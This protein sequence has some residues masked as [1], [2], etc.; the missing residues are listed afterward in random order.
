MAQHKADDMSRPGLPDSESSFE[1]AIVGFLCNWCSYAG[2][3]LAGTSRLS[4]PTNLRVIR[5]MCSGRVDPGLMLEPFQ[6]GAD[7]VM[8]LGCHPA[9][10]HY[11]S[12]NYQAEQ[13]VL[14]V[15]A[16][17]DHLGIDKG[18]LYLD[19]VSAAEGARF[20]ELVA[21]F[22]ARVKRL[23][24]TGCI[25]SREG[26][27]RREFIRRVQVAKRVVEGENFRWLVGRRKALLEEENVYKEHLSGQRFHDLLRTIVAEECLRAAI[28]LLAEEGPI[29]VK[30]MAETLGFSARE[31]L[32]HTAY[33]KKYG[34]L[35]LYDVDG[36]SPRYVSARYR[37][38]KSDT[39]ND[40]MG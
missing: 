33:L 35:E 37:R 19:W 23:G 21:E 31:V 25:E 7:G 12:G 13:R 34:F 4:Y 29:S 3:D 9:D 27:P 38:L 36:R 26:L 10:C 14:C 24:P 6:R 2:A 22:V 28:E 15:Q 1:P 11:L 18:R 5:V 30:D 39:D 40:G 20:A 32:E 16:V 8:V 17:M